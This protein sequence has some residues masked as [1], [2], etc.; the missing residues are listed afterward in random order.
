MIRKLQSATTLLILAGLIALVLSAQ[1]DSQRLPRREAI[2][3][4]REIAGLMEATAT[5]AP[6]LARAGAPFGLSWA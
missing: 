4:Y 1:N 3:L 5:A 2:D 6:E